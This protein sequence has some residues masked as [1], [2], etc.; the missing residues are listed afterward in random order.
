MKVVS[1]SYDAE[2][3]RFSGAQIQVTTKSGTNKNQGTVFYF[4]RYGA[5]SDERGL[6]LEVT[7][8]GGRWCSPTSGRWRE[9]AGS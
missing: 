6:Y 7:P 8:N 2:N 1:N 9:R 5:P 3:G 4:G